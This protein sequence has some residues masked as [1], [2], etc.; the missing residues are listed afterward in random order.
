MHAKEIFMFKYTVSSAALVALTAVLASCGQGAA[1][2]QDA[3]AA[4]PP[5][6][7]AVSGAS[8]QLKTAAIVGPFA[9]LGFPG[10]TVSLGIRTPTLSPRFLR[11]FNGN[12]QTDE[13]LPDS[14]VLFKQ[15]ATWKVVA[16][17]AGS[18]DNACYSFESYNFPGEYLRHASSRVRKDRRDGSPLF[19]QDATWCARTPLDGANEAG[20]DTAFSFESFN[21]PD[22]FLRHYGGEVWLASRTDPQLPSDNPDLFDNDASWEVVAPLIN[23]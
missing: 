4:T 14:S 1:P 21:F 9:F 3:K 15:D 12:A 22:R 10:E 19:D 16:G 18:V 2:T 11:H 20:D 5:K 7:D 17:L 6:L 8:G 13:L 23:F